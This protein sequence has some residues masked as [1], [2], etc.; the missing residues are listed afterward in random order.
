MKEPQ[1]VLSAGDLGGSRLT[2]LLRLGLAT[3][4]EPVE[5]LAVRLLA[6]DGEAWLAAELVSGALPLPP[7]WPP[8][9]VGAAV[10]LATLRSVKAAANALIA[11]HP[12]REALLIGMF[13]YFASIAAGLAHHGDLLSRQ[14]PERLLP[15]LRRLAGTAPGGWRALFQ[16]ALAR[17]SSEPGSAFE[18]GR[19]GSTS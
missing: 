19:E 16:Q 1:D 13:A 11:S 18:T 9:P 5:E 2:R 15:P 8:T 14:E 17:L 12:R 7:G 10:D 3:T 4:E 6:P